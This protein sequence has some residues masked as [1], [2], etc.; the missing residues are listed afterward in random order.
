MDS[1]AKKDNNHIGFSNV[2]LEVYVFVKT[3]IDGNRGTEM[4]VRFY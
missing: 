1:Y 4:F 3:L 2:F